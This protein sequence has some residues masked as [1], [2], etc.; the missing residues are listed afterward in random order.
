MVVR[1]HSRGVRR[2]SSE[3]NADM[4]AEEGALMSNTGMSLL[5]FVVMKSYSP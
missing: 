2:T 5:A 4:S 1:E 3:T